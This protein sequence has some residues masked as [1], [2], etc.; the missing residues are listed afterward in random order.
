MDNLL[1]WKDLQVRA[2]LQ[3]GLVHP[4]ILEVLELMEKLVLLDILEIQ[5]KEVLPDTLDQLVL[6]DGLDLEVKVLK[7]INLVI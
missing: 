4:E 3:D 7:L 2:A 1:V 6:P 5:V